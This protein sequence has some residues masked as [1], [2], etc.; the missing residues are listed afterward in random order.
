MINS[1]AVVSNA[2]FT[3]PFVVDQKLS[4]A[5]Y[6]PKKSTSSNMQYAFELSWIVLHQLSSALGDEYENY[7]SL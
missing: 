7:G 4:L 5:F 2:M 1:K 3:L 6:Q